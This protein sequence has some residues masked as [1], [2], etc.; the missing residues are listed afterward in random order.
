MRTEDISFENVI[1]AIGTVLGT[2]IILLGICAL[3]CGMFF[4]KPT[5]TFYLN[6]ATRDVVGVYEDVRFG[7][8][9][10]MFIG[11]PKAAYNIYWQLT[12]TPHKRYDGVIAP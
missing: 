5:N 3:A 7:Y 10:R 2:T 4:S 1:G 12:R 9:R 11:S 8:D 6:T